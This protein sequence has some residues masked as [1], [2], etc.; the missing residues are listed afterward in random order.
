MV[1]RLTMFLAALLLSVAG[2]MAQTQVNGTVVSQDDGEPVVGATV[3]VVGTQT[4]AVTDINGKFS[5]TCPKGKN[6]LRI[7]YVGM[8]REKD[9]L[10]AGIITY[11][12]VFLRNVTIKKRE[13]LKYHR[14]I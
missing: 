2:A 10:F 5:L 13:L 8:C 7:T 4:G 9:F 14:K 6:M 12:L 1:R 11:K 3:M